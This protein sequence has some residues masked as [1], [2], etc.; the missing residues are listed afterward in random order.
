MKPS[1]TPALFI[2]LGCAGALHLDRA[3]PRAATATDAAAT[4]EKQAAQSTLTVE[5]LIV[6][7]G[8]GGASG[9]GG[10]GGVLQ[11]TGLVMSVDEVITVGAGGLGGSGAAAPLRRRRTEEILRSALW[12]H[13]AVARGRGAVPGLPPA[14]AQAV[15]APTI[16]RVL[17]TRLGSRDRATGVGA[18]TGGGTAQAVAAAVRA[19]LGATRPNSTTEEMVALEWRRRFQALLRITAEAVAVAS[20][21]TAVAPLIQEG[22]AA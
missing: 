21:Q 14:E 22:P 1:D 11:G 5:Y 18:A 2:L 7:G 15:E 12:W 17:P 3:E 9:G 16:C 6:G 4:W 19:A 13:M 20:T 10:G 8:G